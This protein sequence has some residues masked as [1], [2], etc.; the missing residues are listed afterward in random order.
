MTGATIEAGGTGLSYESPSVG[1]VEVSWTGPMLV[2]GQE[3][4]LGP[5]PRWSNAYSE[6]PHGSL[7]TWIQFAGDI[8]DLDFENAQRRLLR[9][10]E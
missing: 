1:S 9:P 8:L 7:R 4:D 10:V 2:D 5:Y 3:V 6:T